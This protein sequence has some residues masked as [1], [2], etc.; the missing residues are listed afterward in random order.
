M[1]DIVKM[2]A[3]QKWIIARVEIIDVLSLCGL[4]YCVPE[5]GYTL[6][7]I[8]MSMQSTHDP[9][10]LFLSVDECKHAKIVVTIHH[11]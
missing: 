1:K 10:K 4:H 5:I 6:C 2:V 8:M 3:K 7:Q 9:T 11:D